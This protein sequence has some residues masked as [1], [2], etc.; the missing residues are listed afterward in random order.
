MRE[1]RAARGWL[2]AILLVSV[3]INTVGITWGLP[4]DNVTWA[5]DAL[6]PLTPMAIGKH[7]MFGEK[8]NSGWFYFKYPLGHPLL[9]LVAQAPYLAW[10]RVTGQFHTPSSTYPYGFKDPEP[11]LSGLALLTRIVSALLSVGVAALAYAIATSLFGPAAGVVAAALGAGCYPFVFYGHTS[12]VDMPLLF[13]IAL[14]VA[15]A[16]WCAEHNST[17]AAL[18]SGVAVAMALLTKEQSVGVLVAVPV[19]W[20]LRRDRGWQ[21]REVV[22]HAWTAGAALVA[23]TIIVGNVWWNP[24]GYINRWRFL[25]GILPAEIREKY[26]PYQFL[27]QVPKGF[28]LAGEMTHLFKVA[29]VVAQALTV[30]VMLLC[31]GGAAWA[32]W[33]RPRFAAIPLLLIASYYVFSLRAAAL[34]P[35]RYTMPLLYGMLILGS[36]A[37]GAVIDAVGGLT[38]NGLRIA[39][40]AMMVVALGCAWLPGIEIDRLLKN[41]PRYAAEQWLRAHASAPARIE[42]YQQPTYLPRFDPTMKVSKVPVSDRTIELFQQRHPDFVVLSSGGRAGL[43]G[44]Y[45]K[46]WQ[47]GKPIFADFESAK[48]FFDR[49]RSEQ[50]GYRQ[51]AR[52]HTSSRWITP[53]IN[54]VNPEI[55]IFAPGSG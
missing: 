27:V 26:A 43:T 35:V 14:A 53:R 4:N 10:L 29:A 50:L 22:R 8:W 55:T 15:A 31:V 28:S 18:V 11:E 21:W 39:A 44:R 9:L 38:Q 7:V 47:P 49:L 41:D 36:A 17:G 30:P 52:F 25:L 33:R 3:C 32:L 1:Q 40:T 34:V 46:D 51:V 48:L 19:M 23:V 5:A 37:A 13:W 12:N 16:L 45:V 6:Q 20:W 54:S 42:T 2:V 24:A